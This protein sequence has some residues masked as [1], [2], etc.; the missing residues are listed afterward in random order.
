MRW[1]GKA[2]H[3]AKSQ[4]CW[5]HSRGKL[6]QL[7]HLYFSIPINLWLNT[8]QV[9]GPC[10]EDLATL[11]FEKT[12]RGEEMQ[13]LQDNLEKLSPPCKQQVSNYTEEEAEHIEL[14][15]FITA[16]CSRFL[17][18]HCQVRLTLLVAIKESWFIYDVWFSRKSWMTETR[19]K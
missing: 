5:S 19:A 7:I 4:Q 13:C 18:N 14:N 1:W 15:P 8:F 6:L 3:E 12:G 16:Y 2:R 10:I 17:E 9:E 11:C